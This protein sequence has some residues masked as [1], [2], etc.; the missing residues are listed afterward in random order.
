LRSAFSA[1]DF[2]RA[3]PQIPPGVIFSN[4]QLA[5]S[6]MILVTGATGHIGNVL[7]RALLARGKTVRALVRPGRVPES[8]AGLEVEFA[9]GDVLDRDSLRQAVRGAELVYHLAA[10][11]SLLPGPDPETERVNLEGTRNLLAVLPGSGV[12]RLVFASSIY[13]L[14]PPSGGRPLD[15]SCPFDPGRAR[16]AYDRSKAQASLEVQAAAGR[17][18]DAVL[19]CPTAVIGPCDF[20]G[21]DAGRGIR[22]N[23][24]PGLNFYVDGAYDFVDVR[25]VADGFI[26]AAEK[27]RPGA[28]YILGGERLTVR[29]V[30]EIVWEASGT[31][32]LGI[33][34]PA[35][36]ARLAARLLPTVARL[37]AKPP[38]FTPYALEALGS[39]SFVRH[40]RAEAELGYHTRPA[41]QAVLDA[42]R[43]LQ[44]GSREETGTASA[45]AVQENSGWDATGEGFTA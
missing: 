24:R 38:L 33:K 42:V 34:V 30:A 40:D 22:Y 13:A 37:T 3:H 21:S 4:S 25:D 10:R 7:V 17:G 19:V 45:E 20:Q 15:E 28:V 23:L 39:N 12:R 36:L 43:W 16:G 35:R 41:R 5:E 26:R 14:R 8:L 32:H 29:Q 44:V 2:L 11:I 27:G 6:D 1:V 18:L 31:P 9:R